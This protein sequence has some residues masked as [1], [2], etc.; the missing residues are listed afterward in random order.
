MDKFK[1]TFW[2]LFKLAVIVAVI[3]IPIRAYVAQ[4]FIVSGG[5]MLPTFQP[6]EYLII[7]ELSYLWRTPERGEVVVFRYPKDPD[8]FFIKRVIALP[9]ETVTVTKDG[10]Q[11][12]NS[13]GEKMTFMENY[14]TEDMRANWLPEA[15]TL[16]AGEYFV[17][18]DNRP[19]S[20]DSRAWGSV[21][22]DLIKGR[23]FVRLLPITN[24]DYLPG[25]ANFATGLK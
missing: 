25:E 18:G 22:E 20:L 10:I 21:E 14:L 9:G 19:A 1:E 2:E 24:I 17:L 12:T 16:K 8:K 5:S 7:D 15:V 4:P 23:A 13:N 11:I 6:G 3:V